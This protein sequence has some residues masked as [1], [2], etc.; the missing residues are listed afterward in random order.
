[1][2]GADLFDVVGLRCIRFL[3]VDLIEIVLGRG[4]Y[5][6]KENCCVDLEKSVW[7]ER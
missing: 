1:M 6:W 4:G 7:C 3:K 2:F 5:K